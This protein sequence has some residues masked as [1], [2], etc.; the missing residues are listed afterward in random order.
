M[1][2]AGMPRCSALFVSQLS[3]R[4]WY[5]RLT[6]TSCGHLPAAVAT[7]HTVA[8]ANQ[9]GYETEFILLEPRP[10]GSAGNLSPVGAG[11]YCQCRSLDDMS[12]SATLIR[13]LLPVA[14]PCSLI[15]AAEHMSAHKTRQGANALQRPS[16]S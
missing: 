14:S 9:V 1:R 15:A 4:H 7:R 12:P 10:D 5:C 3:C 16:P 2:S 11:Q 6:P 8:G 13:S